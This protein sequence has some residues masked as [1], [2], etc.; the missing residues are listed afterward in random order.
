MTTMPSAAPQPNPYSGKWWI[1]ITVSCGSLMAT[2]DA[3][4]VNIALPVLSDY[5]HTPLNT[6]AWVVIAYLLV[7]TALLLVMGRLSDIRGRRNIYLL[8]F[9]LFTA[10]SALC[11]LA[12]D[13]TA[14]VAARI[15]QGVG[16][17][18]IFA[19]GAAI[20][21]NAFPPSE[22]GRAL[23]LNGTIVAIGLTIGPTVGGL[24]LDNLGWRSIFYINVPIGII[25]ILLAY[26]TLP[27][28][29]PP[30]RHAPFDFMGGIV[31]AIGLLCVMAG[32]NLGGMVGF[33]NILPL[34]LL[35]GGV[36]LFLLFLWTELHTPDPLIELSLF[37]NR[38]FSAANIANFFSFM[39]L[40]TNTLMMP[41]FLETVLQQRPSQAG[42]ILTS[43]PLALMFVAP[44][45][46]WLS[47]RTRSVVVG[48]L[49]LLLSAIGLFL[50]G[51]MGA[52][53]STIGV[54]LRL[55]LVG[56]G[57]GIFQSPN[58]SAIMGSVPRQRLG[59]AAGMLATM[60]NLGQST[61]IALTSAIYTLRLQ[62]YAPAMQPG[63]GQIPTAPTMPQFIGAFHDV[64][65][66]GAGL[67]MVGFFVSLVRG[68]SLDNAPPETVSAS[69]LK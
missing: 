25:T 5:F 40:A 31:L 58:N 33:G 3:S 34:F 13:E 37:R 19:N 60:R 23:G 52:T 7:I 41:F 46:G 28:E 10:A 56:L 26:F 66:F 14:L 30:E 39:G 43:V 36:L 24:L 35:V 21:I 38:L 65:L 55:A 20:L 8:G 22:R 47:D 12:N 50:L 15:L 11:G 16:A 61:G 6:L 32:L 63:S 68:G 64:Y 1:W 69:A 44:L 17:A 18:M 45:S 29:T 59:I 62:A 67:A 2:I 49:G 51:N 4:I 9:A 53:T 54:V 48:S 27:K 42:L 57:N